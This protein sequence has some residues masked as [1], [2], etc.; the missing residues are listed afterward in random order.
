MPIKT[1]QSNVD[2]FNNVQK[3]LTLGRNATG[4]SDRTSSDLTPE[5]HRSS[6]SMIRLRQDLTLGCKAFWRV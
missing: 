1:R 3:H 5:E 2:F 4:E 6:Q